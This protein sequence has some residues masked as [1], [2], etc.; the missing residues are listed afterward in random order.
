MFPKLRTSAQDIWKFVKD[1]AADNDIPERDKKVLLA[2]LALIA[3]PIDL[4]PDW[5][6]VLG[7]LDDFVM[8]A[9][10][11]DYFFEVLD[12]SVLLRHYPFGMKSF[13]RIKKAASLFSFF[14]PTIIKNRLWTYV[15]S[16]YR[17]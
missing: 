2:L 5:I 11:L 3:S 4:I 13:I 12:Q 15:G 1:V 17:K 6:P 14:V 10:I 16:P 7:Q 9:L 8:L